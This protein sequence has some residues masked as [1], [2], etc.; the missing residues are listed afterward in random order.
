MSKSSNPYP[1]MSIDEV[2][3]IK[4]QNVEH[5]VWAEGYEA[6]RK[7]ERTGEDESKLAD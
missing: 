3:G 7:D 5:R 6:G 4:I 2:S 1:E